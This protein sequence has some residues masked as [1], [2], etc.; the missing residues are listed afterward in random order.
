MTGILTRSN[1]LISSAFASR[2][3]RSQSTTA[4]REAGRAPRHCRGQLLIAWITAALAL[5]VALVLVVTLVGLPIAVVTRRWEAVRKLGRA[6]MFTGA[7]LVPVFVVDLIFVFGS[8]YIANAQERPADTGRAV[9]HLVWGGLL[10]A[11]MLV[12][13]R[14]AEL[15]GR[16]RL[17]Q[18]AQSAKLTAPPGARCGRHPELAATSICHR[19]GSFFCER[20]A[21]PN[22]SLCRACAQ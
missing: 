5:F 8:A 4:S 16:R 14:G 12:G 21:Q 10:L 3:E 6:L 17:A 2:N 13:G 11:G 7:T 22:E 1:A 15:F 20:C 18:A 19:C 9:N